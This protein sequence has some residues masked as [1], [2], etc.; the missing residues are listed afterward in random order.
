[1]KLGDTM[2]EA[3]ELLGGDRMDSY[4]DPK[5]LCE[6]AARIATAVTGIQLSAVDVV[7]V[8]I[9]VKFAREKN[10]HKFDNCVDLCGYAEI[11]N[12]IKENENEQSN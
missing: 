12:Y 9:A 4:G 1:M 7:D 6:H 8:M 11:R 3:I 10:A 5:K 2:K